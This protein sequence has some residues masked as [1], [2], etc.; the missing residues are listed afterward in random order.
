MLLSINNDTANCRCDGCGFEFSIPANLP[1]S[2]MY[3]DLL[4]GAYQRT[5]C[6][7]CVAKERAEKEAEERRKRF[8]E[9]EESLAE[10]EGKAGFP[11]GFQCL[12]APFMR[13]AAVFFYKNRD[14]SL[15]VSGET[16]TGKTSSALYVLGLMMKEREW[17]IKYYSR[18]TLFAEYVKAKT[19]NNDSE[20]AFLERLGW[21]DYIVIDELVG[22]KGDAM[23]SDSSQELLFN[24][25]DGVY[26]NARKAKV[27]ILGN[28]Y[29]GSLDSL[30]SDVAPLK[31]RLRTSFKTDVFELLPDES[32]VVVDETVVIK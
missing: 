29:D 12:N 11:K 26:C 9:L 18:H 21:L 6:D 28:F 30:V 3:R 27:W 19:S 10:R 17:K 5:K 24:L 22:K 7:K 13:Q 16:G 2:G 32:D 20:D 14:K 4:M 25:V 23:L 1:K 15:I 31:R 8:L